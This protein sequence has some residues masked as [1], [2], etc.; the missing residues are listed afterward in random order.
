MAK[1]A[2]ILWFCLAASSSVAFAAPNLLFVYTDDQAFDTV[3]ALGNAEI[4]TPTLDRLVHRGFVFTNAYCQGGQSPAVCVPSRVMLL[5]GKSTFHTP[6]YR[7]KTYDGPTLGKTFRE[8][9]YATLAVTKPGNSFPPAH[10]DFEKLVEIPHIGAE[11]NAKC[12]DAVLDYLDGFDGSRPFFIYLA[13]SMPHDPRTAE[14]EFHRLYDPEKITLSPD[15]MAE[16]PLDIG[17]L[18][19]RDEKL[20]AYPRQP[21]EMR[22]HLADYYACITSLDH[23]LGRILDRLK[24]TGRL[25]DTVIIFS[26]DQG[27]AVGGRQGLMGKQNLYESFKSPL[28]FAGPGIPHG[29]SDAMVYLFDLYPTA[30]DLCGIPTPK[31]CDGASLVPIIQGKRDSVRDTLFAVYMDTQ[32]MVRD[33]ALEVAVVS[34][35]RQ[36]STVRS[37]ARSPRVEKPRRK[38]RIRRSTRRDETQTRRAARPL[39]RRQSAPRGI[40]DALS[41]LPRGGEGREEGDDESRT[42]LRQSPRLHSNG[43]PFPL[44]I[45]LKRSPPLPL[46]RNG[47]EGTK[48]KRK[49]SK[50]ALLVSISD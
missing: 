31:A 16:S 36:V 7:A 26:S 4:E 41:P 10:R 15:Y 35:A 23:H 2:A 32:R 43:G 12:A 28:I 38:P 19:I 8:A 39:R 42:F 44:P 13:P 34:Q 17:V 45:V 46:P 6:P 18:D 1:L 47:G 21:D 30:C 40:N 5:T 29:T 25:D 27:L 11:T 49:A 48:P 37:E 14:P 33:A 3:R 22:R 20:A 9:G 24:R 50:L